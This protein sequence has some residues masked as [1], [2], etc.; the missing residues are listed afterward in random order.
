MVDAALDADLK[1]WQHLAKCIPPDAH[2]SFARPTLPPP[3]PPTVAAALD[4]GCCT[5]LPFCSHALIAEAITRSIAGLTLDSAPPFL[6]T[7]KP[8]GPRPQPPLCLNATCTHFTRGRAPSS[9]AQP[10]T[11]MRMPAPHMG[12]SY[13]RKS[14][15][16][17]GGG[18][19]Q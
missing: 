13:I 11:V 6:N 19:S 10:I 1:V 18:C 16:Q 14:E 7:G 9:F 8:A 12:S 15:P 4:P 2:F 3:P 5:H 17:L